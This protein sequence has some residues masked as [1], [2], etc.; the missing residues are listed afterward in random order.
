MNFSI[1]V[2][3]PV[4]NRR[5]SLLRAVDSVVHQTLVPDEIIVA[6][7]A[8]N[9]SVKDFLL[10][11]RPLISDRVK[12]VRTSGNTGVSGA[13]NL[14]F[15]NS[16]GSL[17][18]LL[19]SDDYWHPEKLDK[20]LAVFA[21]NPAVGIVSCQQYIVNGNKITNHNKKLIQ[22][23]LFD[24]LI[25]DW[26]PPNPSTLL[27]RRS[28][29]ET[30]PFNENIRYLEDLDWW[31]KVAL[32]QPSVAYVD[33][34]LMFYCLDENNRLSYTTYQK[35]FTKIEQLISLW[36][37][38]IIRLR[39]KKSF[40]N[41]QKHLITYNAIDAFVTCVRKKSFVEAFKIFATYL[42]SEKEF[43]QLI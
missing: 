30:V 18:A 37:D 23:N 11:K 25:S 27:L 26:H 36:K 8:S 33:E 24:Q 20:Q 35:R 39:G 17:I 5:E 28:Y 34:P 43:Y 29:L 7:D 9:F 22:E 13:R 1:S 32:L 41:F 19:D 14:A 2:L 31:L 10:A 42:R 38:D 6:D 15:Q 40:A 3:I 4:Y 21:Q 16:T 12:V